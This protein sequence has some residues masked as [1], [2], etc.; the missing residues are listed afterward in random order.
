MSQFPIVSVLIA[1][2]NEAANIDECLRSLINQEYPL[3]HIE[4][5]IGD[6]DSSDETY[7]LANKWVASFSFIK[8]FKITVGD[9]NLKGK[10][11]VLCQLA[12]KANGEIFCITDADVE[13]CPTWIGTLVNAMIDDTAIVTGVTTV[14]G[15]RLFAKLQ[16]ADWIFYTAL[17]HQFA[18]KNSPVTAMGNN[19]A[20]RRNAYEYV[21]G[22]DNI[23]FSITEDFELFRQVIKAG[24]KFKSI[25]CLSTLAHTKP[26]TK[27]NQLFHQRKRWLT[28]ALQLPIKFKSGLII[29]CLTLPLLISIG[30]FFSWTLMCAILIC[31][32]AFNIFQLRR[33]YSWIASPA[34]LGLYLY[35]PYSLLFN[36]C[37]FL[38]QI[39]PV[40]VIWKGRS[41]P[42]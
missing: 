35:F 15:Q 37:F 10:A 12:K 4:I 14:I 6:D 2:R 28:G 7:N 20:I 31:L 32:W 8:A 22:Y 41:Y 33:F 26:V 24:F 16:N 11:N 19:M 42:A 27:L 38:F 25:F 17:G 30:C 39:A 23:P 40:S 18:S 5:L 34:N 3:D 36:F 9:D 29:Q 13:V 21:G 1:A